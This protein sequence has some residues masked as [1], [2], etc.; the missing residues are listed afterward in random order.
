MNLRHRGEHG[1]LAARLGRLAVAGA[2]A[3]SVACAPFLDRRVAPP[4]TGR[5]TAAAAA[6]VRIIVDAN[7]WRGSLVET[8]IPVLLT[9]DNG[10]E[11]PLRVRYRD[12]WLATGGASRAVLPVF[13]LAQ[14]DP[15]VPSRY[16]YPWHA[17][18]L[19]PHLI[20]F[21][22]GFW[23]DAWA[24]AHDRQYYDARYRQLTALISPT[25]E[26]MRRALPEGVLE[27]GGYITGVLYF[28]KPAGPTTR[29][30]DLID[31]ASIE[32]FGVVDIAFIQ[33]Q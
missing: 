1:W 29:V 14:K 27:R 25:R 31:A 30:M 20:R 16:S 24:F 10:S 12:L 3:G 7:E 22:R 26:M 17:F 18:H 15:R 4:V 2:I 11:R 23:T 9:I 13:D 8:L 21:Y 28:R 32:R 6:G 33:P 19:A 5:G